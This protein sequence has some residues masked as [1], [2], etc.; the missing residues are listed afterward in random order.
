MF[1]VD[2]E[3]EGVFFQGSV[4]LIVIVNCQRFFFGGDFYV[5]YEERFE[6]CYIGFLEFIEFYVVICFQFYF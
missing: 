2:S 4:V 3:S 6:V 5:G 1:I